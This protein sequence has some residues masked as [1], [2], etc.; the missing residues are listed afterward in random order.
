MNAAVTKLYD[1][2]V[3]ANTKRSALVHNY[4]DTAVTH[5]GVFLNA[6]ELRKTFFYERKLTSVPALLRWPQLRLCHPVASCLHPCK[7]TALLNTQ[8]V[9]YLDSRFHRRIVL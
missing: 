4:M 6:P 9:C 1:A 2:A 7:D 5:T 8:R 3:T